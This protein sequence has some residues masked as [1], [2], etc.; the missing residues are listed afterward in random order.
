M[1]VIIKVSNAGEFKDVQKIYEDRFKAINKDVDT[2]ITNS[3]FIDS[4]TK[5]FNSASR[6]TT[7]RNNYGQNKVNAYDTKSPTMRSRDI[8]LPNQTCSSGMI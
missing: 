1:K 4:M 6:T 8:N 3:Q 2:G 5:P 7:P